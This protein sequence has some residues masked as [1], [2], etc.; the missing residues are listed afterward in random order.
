MGNLRGDREKGEGEKGKGGKRRRKGE[1]VRRGK[2]T[3]G[4]EGRDMVERKENA[5][6]PPG[7]AC[8]SRPGHTKDG[9]LKI[10]K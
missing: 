6:S 7:H 10:R 3:E 1:Q 4:G 8:S 5:P 9:F 2:K